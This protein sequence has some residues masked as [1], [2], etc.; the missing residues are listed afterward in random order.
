MLVLSRKIGE[1]ICVGDEVRI[2]VLSVQG[3]QVRLGITAPRQVHVL[4]AELQTRDPLPQ[5]AVD[6]SAA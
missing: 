5:S 4:R 3:Q 1:V 2:T 6:E